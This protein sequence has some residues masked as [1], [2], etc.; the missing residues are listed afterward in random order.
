MIY[1]W[2]EACQHGIYVLN[3]YFLV[4]LQASAC[5]YTRSGP[6][7]DQVSLTSTDDDDSEYS[8]PQGAATGASQLYHAQVSH[9][10]QTSSG[11]GIGRG[12]GRGRGIQPSQPLRRPNMPGAAGGATAKS[13]GTKK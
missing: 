1:Y 9:S 5:G 12:R 3:M 10:Q 6:T 7:Y 8:A 2:T 11:F 4:C 13:Q